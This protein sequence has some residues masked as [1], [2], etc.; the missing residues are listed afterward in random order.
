VS[1][2]DPV[3]ATRFTIWKE[4]SMHRV[5]RVLA[6]AGTLALVLL[7][8]SPALAHGHEEVGDHTF[9]IGFE[10]EP[11]FAG[12]PNA[13]EVTVSHGDE[14]VTDIAAGQLTVDVSLGDEATTFDLVPAFEVGEWGTPGVYT[15]PFIPSEPGAY[16]FHVHGDLEGEAVDIEMTGGPETFSE[17]EDPAAASFPAVTSGPS[18]EDLTA[19]VAASTE[20]ADQAKA[21][22]DQAAAEIAAANDAASSATTVG[23]AG[24]VAGILGLVLG[25]IAFATSRRSRA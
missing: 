14:P 1:A 16:T 13:V 24:L 18:G 6:A 10:V 23:I 21:A 17:V 5:L 20:R 12:Q 25:A 15:A 4:L 3:L 2:G 9:V 22:A 11:A 8:A 7:P 19:A